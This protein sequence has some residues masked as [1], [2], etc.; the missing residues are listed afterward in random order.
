MWK[1]NLNCASSQSKG[2]WSANLLKLEKIEIV[3][4]RKQYNKS[5]WVNSIDQMKYVFMSQSVIIH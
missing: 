1:K 2:F 3:Q 4:N 5:L